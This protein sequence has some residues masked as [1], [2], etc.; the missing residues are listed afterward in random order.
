[1][2]GA[3]GNQTQE[4]TYFNWNT[5]TFIFNTLNVQ[6]YYSL[7]DYFLID[8][9]DL[10]TSNEMS[11][12]GRTNDFDGEFQGWAE[13]S[14]TNRLIDLVKMWITTQGLPNAVPGQTVQI[15]FP[16]GAASDNLYAYQFQGFWL[17]EEV[18]HN[19]GDMFITKLLL[20]RQGVD[21]NNSTS[22]L[23]ATTYKRS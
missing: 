14:Y 2:Y 19:C 7:S 21:T 1:M 4:Y 10:T 8:K 18:V 9:S 15:F 5:G 13:G 16:Q 22:L 3:F 20:T 17:I 12:S 11:A 6:D 23:P